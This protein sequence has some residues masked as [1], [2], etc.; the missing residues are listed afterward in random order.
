MLLAPPSD[1]PPEA[2]QNLEVTLQKQTKH[3]VSVII[4]T[5]NCDRYLSEAIDSVLSQTLAD[6]EIIIVDDGSTDQTQQVLTPYLE[7]YSEQIRYLYQ[8][9]QGVAAA[10]NRGIQAARGE[11]IAFLDA[12][13]YF[14]SPSKLA[15]QVACF[16]QSSDLGLVQCGWRVVDEQGNPLADKHPWKSRSTLTLEDWIRWKTV[17]P[18]AMM[19][20]RSWLE[21]V[22][23]FDLR[24]PPSEDVDLALRLSLMGCRAV[25]LKQVA[26]G[27]RQHGGNATNRATRDRIWKQAQTLEAVLDDFFARSNLP[28][29][30]QKIRSEVYY[31][32]LTW[33]AWCFYQGGDLSTMAA[34]LKRASTY[35]VQA[36]PQAIAQWI[37]VFTDLAEEEN[38]TLDVVALTQQPEWQQLVRSLLLPVTHAPTTGYISKDLAD[39]KLEGKLER[40]TIKGISGWGWN[41]KSPQDKLTIEIL[42]GKQVIDTCRA[43]QFRADLKKAGKGDGR[44]AF[45][46]SLPAAL[47]DGNEHLVSVRIAG[48][49]HCLAG[50]PLKFKHVV[51]R[52]YQNFEEYLRW[53]MIYREL[54]YP[55]KEND[56]RILGY[57]DWY[58]TYLRERYIN[59]PQEDKVSVIMPVYNREAV[60]SWAINSVLKQ[61]YQNWELIIVDDGSSDRTVQVVWQF[62][63]SRIILHTLKENNGVSNARNI[64]LSLSTGKYISYLDSDNTWHPDFL[65]LMINSLKEKAGAESIYCAQQRTKVHDSKNLENS[66]TYSVLFGPFNR[67]LLENRNYIDIN[68]F[69]HTREVYE[70]GVQFNPSMRRLVDW[71]FIL[72]CTRSHFPLSLPCIL[73]DYYFGIVDNQITDIEN[74]SVAEEQI[75]TY[76]RDR[77]FTI[78]LEK[79]SDRFCSPPGDALQYVFFAN[80][81]VKTCPGKR[82]VSIIIPSYEVPE[83]LEYCIQSVQKFTPPNAY[84]LIVVDNNSS[85]ETIAVLKRLQCSAGIKVIYNSE[86]MGFTY[87][88]NQGIQLAQPESDIVL[89]NNDALVTQGWLD[90]MIEVANDEDSVGI[91]VPRQVLI[92]GTKTVDVHVPHC[93]P[94]SEVDVSLSV[95]HANILDPNY[96]VEKGLIELSF[97]PFFCVYIPRECIDRVGLLDAK[98]G[99]HYRSDR[100]YCDVVRNVA[101]MR[102]IYTPHAKLYHFLQKATSQLKATDQSAYKTMFV[103]NTWSEAQKRELFSSGFLLQAGQD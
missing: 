43:D 61:S 36:A 64:G 72:S 11:F 99:R 73:S 15:D 18:S 69:M 39:A 90:A 63:D 65:L 51:D 55:I 33:L 22:G 46:A 98:N 75:R 19:I 71:Y 21:R 102:I 103:E 52:P 44:Y 26:V 8:A 48:T 83:Y 5:Y 25:W 84:E 45:R 41:R 95:H 81:S 9:N 14:L 32:T 35:S 78:P 23:G 49:E 34:Y 57:M 42:D 70:R 37:Q 28:R 56:K 13:D 85:P 27:Y 82:L 12:D 74:Y 10:R 68:A 17:L 30:L 87:A 53:A 66:E 92:P 6:V 94:R 89:L 31:H 16:D 54:K 93:N 24:F 67:S 80:Q 77:P 97:A 47:R 62:H 40:V 20:R 96:N 58:A 50:S 4:P 79:Q 91:I 59:L 101:N 38:Q 86:N 29:S 88:V 100:L 3:L 2:G 1:I 76:L 7:Q 60:V